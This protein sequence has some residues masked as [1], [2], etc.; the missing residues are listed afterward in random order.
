MIPEGG[1]VGGED[2]VA[3][4]DGGDVGVGEEGL[5][6]GLDPGESVLG[7]PHLG[8]EL[9]AQ[10]DREL[11]AGPGEGAEDALVRVVELDPGRPDRLHQRHRV[12]RR[13]QVVGDLAVVDADR[14][15]H[16]RRGREACKVGGNQ[17]SQTAEHISERRRRRRLNGDVLTGNEEEEMESEVRRR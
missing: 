14:S 12:V 6:V 5:D 7:V 1:V 16:R 17:T 9:V 15:R 10:A 4:G 13:R 8:Q 11:D 2:L 3:D